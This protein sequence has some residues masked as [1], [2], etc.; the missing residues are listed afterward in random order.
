MWGD[1][2]K[3]KHEAAHTPGDGPTGARQQHA[4]LAP[5]LQN[6][7]FPVYCVGGSHK[8]LCMGPRVVTGR[9]VGLAA[10]FSLGNKCSKS[11]SKCCPT[12]QQHLEGTWSPPPL[13]PAPSSESPFSRLYDAPDNPISTPAPLVQGPRMLL[14]HAVATGHTFFGKWG[15]LPGSRQKYA[16][17][18]LGRQLIGQRALL[19]AP[20]LDNS[21][22]TCGRWWR[23][24]SLHG[25]C[26]R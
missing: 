10:F 2:N 4:S 15:A 9:W 6:T 14:L 1:P 26:V 22:M 16:F 19:N 18:V 23:T 24:H 17:Q 20:V 12:H 11:T 5:T 25:T 3:T 13:P 21:L 8:G 7:H